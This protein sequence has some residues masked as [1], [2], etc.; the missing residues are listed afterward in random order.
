MNSFPADGYEKL[1]SEYYDAAK[2]PTCANFYEASFILV[3]NWASSYLS[4]VELACEVGCGNSM[5]AQILGEFNNAP[6]LILVDS[7][8]SM[9][10]YSMQYR[11]D[12]TS[13]VLGDA[14]RLPFRSQ[15]MDALLC[16]LGDPYNTNY[17][18]ADI[19]RILRRG[20]TA[21]FTTPSFTWAQAFRR[22]I[23]E[24]IW[25]RFALGDGKEIRVS[26]II[27]PQAEQRRLMEEH[28]L[29]VKD[30]VE[31][32]LS[33]LTATEISPKLWTAHQLNLPVVTGY[34]VGAP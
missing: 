12:R 27:Y 25:A 18:W 13:L 20:A 15:S 29:I 9:L 4:S 24:E 6:K 10:K 14:E 21:F 16:S 2:H 32:P 26:S 31:V 7:A 3:K 8:P 19:K 5:L 17:L 33:D 11:G 30:I 22:D 1:A 34:I 23:S 28:G